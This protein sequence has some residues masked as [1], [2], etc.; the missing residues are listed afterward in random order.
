MGGNVE[1]EKDTTNNGVPLNIRE[2]VVFGIFVKGSSVKAKRD[3]FKA[4]C[5]VQRKQRDDASRERINA[6]YHASLSTVTKYLHRSLPDN[7]SGRNA[8]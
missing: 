5:I 8:H 4:S 7:R 6:N 2:E 1:N 3:S